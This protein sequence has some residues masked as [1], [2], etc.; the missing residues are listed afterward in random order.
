MGKGVKR[1]LEDAL[2]PPEQQADAQRPK[3]GRGRQ[4]EPPSKE[5]PKPA[6]PRTKQ[7]AAATKGDYDRPA[8]VTTAAGRRGRERLDLNLQRIWEP[9]AHPGSRQ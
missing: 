2:K 6:K 5:A 7:A 1:K 4:N 3:T 8:Y 9:F